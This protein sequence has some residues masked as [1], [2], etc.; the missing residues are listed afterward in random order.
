MLFLSFFFDDSGSGGAYW[1]HTEACQV[2]KSNVL[3]ALNKY[4]NYFESI[5]VSNIIFLI[6]GSL[7]LGFFQLILHLT[8]IC[9]CKDN[10]KSVSL[11]FIYTALAAVWGVT[12]FFLFFFFGNCYT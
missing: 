12:I 3:K 7:L 11:F 9:G 2:R 4:I 8:K 10:P 6:F 5:K 1:L